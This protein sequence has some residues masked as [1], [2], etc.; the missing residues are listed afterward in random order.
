MCLA[1]AAC[2]LAMAAMAD[3]GRVA[4]VAARGTVTPWSAHIGTVK[5][6]MGN[7]LTAGE[8]VKQD[9]AS[10]RLRR[11]GLDITAVAVSRRCHE[12]PLVA[13][14]VW[15]VRQQHRLAGVRHVRRSQDYIVCMRVGGTGITEP[16]P[17]DTT[18]VKRS[19]EKSVQSWR[20]DLK[21]LA[22]KTVRACT[23]AVAGPGSMPAVAVPGTPL[24]VGPG[25]PA[26][27]GPGMPLQAMLQAIILALASIRGEGAAAH[28]MLIHK[29]EVATREGGDT[30]VFYFAALYTVVVV[31]LTVFVTR[32]VVERGRL[33]TATQ[34]APPACLT[35]SKAT[36]SQVTY[37][38][39]SNPLRSEF[40]F[41]PLPERD[42]G[43]WLVA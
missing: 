31:F 7:V 24:V 16:N 41:V 25:K 17:Y 6:F 9:P 36:Q 42:Q 22:D 27:A 34:M 29:A 11:K 43:C 21:E 15:A 26:V 13:E 23:P 35:C 10:R 28:G 8:W 39:V 33:W 40:R 38:Y 1:R 12:P 30:P 3:E 37:N 19:W 5:H 4:A 18:V 20:H 14:A 2:Q 32:V